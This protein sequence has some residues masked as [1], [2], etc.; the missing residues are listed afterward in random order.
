M[1]CG[2]SPSYAKHS[3]VPLP[4]NFILITMWMTLFCRWKNWKPKSFI[5]SYIVWKCQRKTWS[6][7]YGQLFLD[8]CRFELYFPYSFLYLLSMES[9]DI[10]VIWTPVSYLLTLKVHCNS[11]RKSLM[12]HLPNKEKHCHHSLLCW[13]NCFAKTTTEQAIHKGSFPYSSGC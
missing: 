6:F 9:K 11:E 4:A 8:F 1:P 7:F 5:C 2:E 12:C 10:Y 13:R 3:A